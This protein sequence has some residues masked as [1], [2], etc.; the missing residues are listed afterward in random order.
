MP[1]H[2]RSVAYPTRYA[3]PYRPVTRTLQANAAAPDQYR[4][5]VAT[6]PDLLHHIYQDLCGW[7]L[8]C[9]CPLELPCHADVLL[10]LAARNL[11][12]RRETVSGKPHGHEVIRAFDHDD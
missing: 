5:W 7:N 10:E 12:N 4:V 8:A 2:T 1:P 9:W 3:N 6:Q 11:T